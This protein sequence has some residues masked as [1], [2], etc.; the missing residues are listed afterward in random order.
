MRE[1]LAFNNIFTTAA[2]PKTATQ[3]SAVVSSFFL[4]DASTFAVNN[5]F[6]ISLCSLY[7]AQSKTVAH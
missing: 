4:S 3:W 6:N 7:V 2:C 1:R 5:V